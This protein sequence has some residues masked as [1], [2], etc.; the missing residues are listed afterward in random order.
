VVGIVTAMTAITACGSSTP[1]AGGGDGI[2]VTFWQNK[3][4][5]EDNAWF[6]KAVDDYN[7]SQDKITVKLTVVPGDAWDQKLKAAQAAGTAPDMYTMNYSAVP[8]NARNSKLAPITEYIDKAG[9]DDLD[10]RFL[11]A[12]TVEGKQYAYPLYYEPSALLYY[13]TDLFEKAGLNPDDPPKTW[14][15]LIAAGKKLK[16]ADKK[17]VPFEIAQNATELSWSTWGAQYGTAG[18]MP[19]SEDWSKPEVTDDYTPLF[20]FYQDLY[21]QGIIPKQALAPYSDVTPLGQGKLGMM[22]GGSWAIGPLLADYPK[23]APNIQV[24]AMPTVDGDPKRTTSTLGG[25]TIGVDAR[26][27]HVK[28]AAS[29]ISWMLAEGAS[30]PRAYFTGTKFTKLS[31]R[32]SIAEDLAQDSGRSANPY[33][34]VMTEATKTA[35]LEP[36]YDWQVSL[37]MGTALEKARRG[38]D[39]DAA[40]KEANA[41]IE[42]TIGDLGLAD[43]KH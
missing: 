6:K 14:D 12:V 30:V 43:Q 41:K 39:I 33:Y 2:T 5:N 42:K 29:A 1:D 38:G 17:I 8:M 3:F 32:T 37:A 34:D 36:T 21:G 19:I 31:P 25:W 11:D 35:I 15:E 22:A 18:H 26:S 23:M 20:E 40:M 7:K 9:W 13:R 27:K 24:A 4:S 16:A 28:E 10:P